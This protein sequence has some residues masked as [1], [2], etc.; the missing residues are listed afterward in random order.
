MNDQTAKSTK[1]K[2]WVT[3]GG[4]AIIALIPF[5]GLIMWLLFLPVVILVGMWGYRLIG[6]GDTKGGVI[7][8]GAAFLFVPF[9]FV[10]PLVTSS[11]MS[12]LIWPTPSNKPTAGSNSSASG[13]DSPVA[14]HRANAGA[15][16]VGTSAD[17]KKTIEFWQKM[18][19]FEI[20]ANTSVKKD[21]RQ[22]PMSESGQFDF[23]KF[24]KDDFETLVKYH[25]DQ[26]GIERQVA[27]DIGNLPILGVDQEVVRYKIDLCEA[28]SVSSQMSIGWAQLVNSLHQQRVQFTSEEGYKLRTA[29]ALLGQSDMETAYQ[30]S[31]REIDARL[32]DWNSVRSREEKLREQMVKREQELK[33][34]LTSRYNKEFQ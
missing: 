20:N 28:W 1:T 2:S 8:L 15:S 29:K 18:R 17:S 26:G 34:L 3:L 11:M 24:E 33:A 31:Q 10:A 16:D 19:A 32:Q 25:L 5:V 14:T 6:M 22:Y 4:G 13:S 30:Q 27:I 12:D 9:A 21:T 7:H 23:T